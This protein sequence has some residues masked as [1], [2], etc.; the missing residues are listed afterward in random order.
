MKIWILDSVASKI[1][2]HLCDEDLATQIEDVAQLLCDILFREDYESLLKNHE[3]NF[4]YDQLKSVREKL[5]LLPTIHMTK[6]IEWI[7]WGRER[8]DNYRFLV[9]MGLSCCHKYKAWRGKVAKRKLGDSNHSY[10]KI[11]RWCEFHEPDLPEKTIEI[12]CPFKNQW[13]TKS[14]F[15]SAGITTPPL[16]VPDEF[17]GEKIFFLVIVRIMRIL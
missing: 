17:K 14:H 2:N 12:P 13:C 7:D 11:L 1:A 5:P 16:L 9:E 8:V 4:P 6:N 15:V 3:G 10:H